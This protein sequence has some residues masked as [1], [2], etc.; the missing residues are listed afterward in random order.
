MRLF[1]RRSRIDAAA[2]DLFAWHERPGAFE[3][4]TPPWERVTV[5]SRS[6]GI[7]GGGR[8]ELVTAV[9]PLRLTWS[10]EHRDYHAGRQFRDVQIR[11]PFRSW[12]HTHRFTPDGPAASILEDSIEYS[13]PLGALSEPFVAPFVEAKLDRMFGYR[14]RI[15]RDDIASHAVARLAPGHRILVSGSTGLIGSALIPFLTTGGHDVVRLVRSTR[16][17]AGAV[18]WDPSAGTIDEAGLAG[19]DAVV[20]LAGENI[21][22]GRWTAARKTRIR[23]SR[24]RGTRLLSEAL[25]RMRAKPRVLVLSSAIGFYGH[26]GAAVLDE[27]SPPGTGF[28]A[29]VCREWEAAARPAEDAGIRIVRL[30]TGVVLTPA[31]GALAKML[32]P[33]RLGAGGR[34][35]DGR[36]FMSWISIDDMVSLILFAI[37]HDALRGP[38]NATAPEPV[39]NRE[40][41]RT[42]A[43][44]LNRPAILPVPAPALRLLFGEMAEATILG[45]LRAVPGRALAAGFRFRHPDLEGALRHLFGRMIRPLAPGPD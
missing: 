14:H 8:V 9:G 34:L 27:D 15:T 18:S 44:V 39:T 31:G 12:D 23:E 25:A 45:S 13:M 37:G 24:V 33:F 30:R 40:F 32:V 20:H 43:S 10:I 38:V 5:A 7:R 28:L 3:R 17:Q 11:G 41:T 6:G 36:Q 26:Q 1:V 22:G 16:P 42:L 21:A 4:L 29:E 19:I 2:E 35:G